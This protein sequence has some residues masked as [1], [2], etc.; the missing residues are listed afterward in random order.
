MDFWAGFLMPTLPAVIVNDMV[1]F[2]ENIA[3]G[4]LAIIFFLSHT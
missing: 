4:R 1:D 2:A 3:E